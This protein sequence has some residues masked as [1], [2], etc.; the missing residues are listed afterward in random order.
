MNMSRSGNRVDYMRKTYVT[1]CVRE[2][3]IIEL[4]VRNMGVSKESRFHN[5]YSFFFPLVFINT[6]LQGIYDGS[7][8]IEGCFSI[9]GMV[10][11]T[12]I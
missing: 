11:S 4:L 8:E 6:C 5:V 9:S 12:S 1:V 2:R 10:S 3:K 7:Y